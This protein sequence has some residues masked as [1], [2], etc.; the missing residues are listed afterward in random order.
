[1]KARLKTQVPK[2]AMNNIETE[3]SWFLEGERASEEQIR[4]GDGLV[5]WGFEAI[6]LKLARGARYTPD[7]YCLY[8]DGHVEFISELIDH[9]T[10]K[11]LGTR[12]GKE[13]IDSAAF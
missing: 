9:D 5:K 7:F 3:W 10:W 1:M 12:N 4:H 6:S 8:A 13:V 11:A 2:P